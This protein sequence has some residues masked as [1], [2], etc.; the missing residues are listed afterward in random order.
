VIKAMFF[1]SEAERE[2]K[3]RVLPARPPGKHSSQLKLH[4]EKR[5]NFVG[6][7]TK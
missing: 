1:R 7:D 6:K 3:R 2:K 4:R 5:R